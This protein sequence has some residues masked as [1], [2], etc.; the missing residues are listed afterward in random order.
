MEG[1][2][3]GDTDDGW[4]TEK[5]SEELKR[6]VTRTSEKKQHLQEDRIRSREWYA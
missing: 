3:E 4:N 2:G 5:S 6:F 1:E